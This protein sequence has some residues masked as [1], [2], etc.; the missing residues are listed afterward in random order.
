MKQMDMLS[1][2]YYPTL[3]EIP[4]SDRPRERM[5]QAG[6][7]ALSNAELLAILLRTGSAEE[8]VMSL[9]CRVLNQVGGLRGLKSASF[10][11]LTSLKGIGPAKALLLMAV[12]EL[13]KRMGSAH[14]SD[15]I[16][17]R[18]PKDAADVMM[19]EMRYHTQE[20]FVCLYLNT[21]NHII[22]RETIF[23]GSLNS[24][25]VHPREVYKEA[26]RRSSASV[27]CLHNHPSGDASPSR[28]DIDVTRRLQEAGRILGIEL[29]DH[30]IIGDGQFYSLK[31]KGHF[32]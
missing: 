3:R 8:S 16:T 17:I 4:E 15:R 24:S 18:S 27:I 20:H 5:M 32:Q 10:E 13:G 31:E 30:I 7:G 23:I 2:E 9:S 19:E 29:L 1:Q 21:K 28:E 11:E 22:G 14:F 25:I 6:P 26:I 12:L